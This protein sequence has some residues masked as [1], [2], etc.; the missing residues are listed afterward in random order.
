VGLLSWLGWGAVPLLNRPLDVAAWDAAPNSLVPVVLSDMFGDE[1]PPDSIPL[2]RAEALTV[3]AVAA[4]QQTL[5]GTFGGLT[6]T[7]SGG[8]AD[9]VQPR[10]LTNTDRNTQSAYL[11]LTRTLADFMF[12][13]FSLWR[14]NPGS[15]GFPLGAWHVPFGK[16]EFDDRD[17]ILIDGEPVDE[18]EIIFFESMVPG[19]LNISTRTLHAAIEIERTIA[20]R[21]RVSVPLTT[22]ENTGSDD[23]SPEEVTDLLE[24]YKAARASR[25]GSTVSYIPSGLK[26]G[27]LEDPESAWLLEARNAIV[28][29]V[30][31]FTGIP[32]TQLEG[33]SSVDSLTYNSALAQLAALT[34]QTAALYLDPIEARL[35]MGD[36][37]PNGQTVKFDRSPLTAMV[38]A[39]ATKTQTNAGAPAAQEAINA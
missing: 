4:A 14:C 23:L 7:A 29:D 9:S 36:V 39:S 5:V 38:A 22:L 17:T 15:D 11:R 3:P 25:D 20:E 6:L 10:W 19:V 30:A 13:G 32:S 21:A 28:S 18:A 34:T 2:T 8:A 27:V 33:T 16:W 1:L 37:T 24:Q 31:K 12:L 35:S 26:L